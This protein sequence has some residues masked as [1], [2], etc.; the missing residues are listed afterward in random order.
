MFLDRTGKRITVE[1]NRQGAGSEGRLVRCSRDA[2]YF[3]L[4]AP[5]KRRM[6]P[7]SGM[8]RCNFARAFASRYAPLIMPGITKL[9]E[10]LRAT[11]APQACG[12][13][14]L[15]E[16]PPRLAP[17]PQTRSY[18]RGKGRE[19]DSFRRRRSLGARR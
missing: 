4:D 9:V 7:V 16:Q 11:M 1:Q 19:I 2:G 3:V 10:A 18:R 8:V 14:P 17:L 12:H 15:T 13:S 6:S 5:A